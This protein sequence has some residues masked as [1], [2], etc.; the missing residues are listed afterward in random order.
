MKRQLIITKENYLKL[1]VIYIYLPIAIFLLGWVKLYISIPIVLLSGYFVFKMY[2][3][4]KTK[5]ANEETS[6]TINLWTFAIILIFLAGICYLAGWGGWAPQSNDWN[7]HNAIMHDMVERSWPVYYNRSGDASM[8]TYYIGQ[9][10]LPAFIGKLFHSFRVAE[11]MQFIWCYFGL[12]LVYIGLIRTLEVKQEVKKLGVAFYLAFFSGLLIVVQRLLLYFFEEN[13][14]SFGDYHWV[15]AFE[16]MLQ[17]RSN[18][19]DLRWVYPQCLVAWRTVLLL[20]EF[21]DEIQH[22]VILMIPLMLY[23][24]IP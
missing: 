5:K 13:F 15:R 23:S 21:K 6:L 22:Y 20:R 16:Y 9:Y 8:L 19:V 7:K 2:Q 10:V 18:F 4:F 17:Y 24:T 3:C 11:L 14:I 12:V 1:I